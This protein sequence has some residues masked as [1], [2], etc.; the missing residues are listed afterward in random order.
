MQKRQLA[1]TNVLIS[2]YRLSA[3]RPTIGRYR[4][5]AD[6]RCIYS[7]NDMKLML[8]Q[9]LPCDKKHNCMTVTVSQILNDEWHGETCHECNS[10]DRSTMRN[11]AALPPS[12]IK[13]TTQ[14]HTDFWIFNSMRCRDADTATTTVNPLKCS[15]VRQLRLTVFNAIFNFWHWDTLAPTAERQSV[16]IKN[17][18]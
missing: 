5:L 8:S 2:R 11:S 9:L 7:N 15:G 3:K 18:G 1:N 17:V 16:R 6:Y 13:H 10:M 4:L 12:T 14:L